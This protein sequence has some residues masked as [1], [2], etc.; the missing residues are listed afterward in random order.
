MSKTKTKQPDLLTEEEIATG[1]PAPEEFSKTSRAKRQQVARVEKLPPPT[2]TNMLSLIASC[3]ADPKVDVAKMRELLTMQREIMAEEA[4][5]AFTEAFIALD[6]PTIDRDGR[7]DEGITRSG[8]QGKKTRYATFENLNAKCAKPLKENGFALWFEPDI[9][10]NGQVIVRGHLD[11]VKGHGKSCAIPLG[12]DA[13]GNKNP[14][15]QAASSISYG[16]RIGMIAILNIQTFAP[17]DADRDGYARAA[18]VSAEAITPKQLATIVETAE[19]KNCPVER[20]RE[21]LN[22][23]RGPYG[24]ID[25]L[26]DLPALRFDEAIKALESWKGAK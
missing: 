24:E 14:G 6:L 26:S 2:P 11:H 13:S 5:I 22:K 8:R 7:I 3:A 16:K 20:L 17:E 21:F 10:P 23:R 12:L 4:R 9:G 15:Q 25:K 1:H 18:E 19:A